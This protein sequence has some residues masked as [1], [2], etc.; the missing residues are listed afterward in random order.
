MTAKEVT[1]FLRALKEDGIEHLFIPKKT[2]KPADPKDRRPESPER[3]A[4][5]AG[6]KNIKEAMLELRDTVLACKQCPVLVKNRT[7]VV[8]GS[9][10]IRARL[11]FVG[12]A[13]GR[14]EDLQG[15]P[16]VGRAGQLLTKI[17]EAMGMTREEVFI[18]NVLKCRPPENRPPAPDEVVNCRPFLKQQL[19]LIRPEIIVA[20][21]NHAC[22]AL[23][24]TDKGI[25]QLRGSMQSYEGIPVMC[26]YHPA[27]LL[28][29]PAEKKKVWEDMKKVIRFLATQKE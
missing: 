23:L 6:S 27:Y 9:G 11:V 22:Q 26:T 10:N 21:G 3:Q 5:A 28:R 19:E 12:E 17:I 24:S 14:D 2:K 8:F 20:L 7:K 29:N 18:C 1:L 13:P 16:F 15:L 25:S 4:A